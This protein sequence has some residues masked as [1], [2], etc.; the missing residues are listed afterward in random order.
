MHEIPGFGWLQ[1]IHEGWH[2]STVQAGHENLVEILIGVSALEAAAG[3]KI[4]WPD[5]IVFAIGKRC[6]RRSIA[7]S[8]RT[9]TLPA[10]HPLE[11]RPSA[12][13][14]LDRAGSLYWN[15]DRCSTPLTPSRR[16][17]LDV[18]DEVSPHLSGERQPR[19]HVCRDEA[20]IDRP[21]EI[22]IGGKSA[23][24]SG[25]A[26]EHSGS[27]VT[28]LGIDPL[29]VLSES[30]TIRAVAPDAKSTIVFFARRRVAR[31]TSD[32]SLLRRAH[33]HSR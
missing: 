27:E 13:N 18:R 8:G 14:A 23:R 15:D 22:F 11:D 32:A 26:L 3:C 2:R 31:K 19:W 33:A 5:W 9:V 28:R 21:V 7:V 25:S 10:L 4:V 20:A 1:V 17:R 16:E 12:K 30:V 6:R 29:R 24:R